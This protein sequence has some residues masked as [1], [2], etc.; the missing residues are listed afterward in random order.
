MR[1]IFV[2]D[3]A[4]ARRKLK[5]YID[6]F[7]SWEIVA[8]SID[9]EDAVKQINNLQPDLVLLDIQLTTGTGFEVLRQID[10]PWPK[11][12]FITAYDNYAVKAFDLHAQ[13]YILKPF[14]QKRFEE[15]VKK[16]ENHGNKAHGMEK[17]IHGLIN[18]LQ[19]T[20]HK[21]LLIQE[22]ERA[23]YCNIDD[24]IY[25]KSE[26]NYV[27]IYIEDCSYI[28]R[29]SLSSILNELSPKNFQQIHRSYVVNVN[30]IKEIQTWFKGGRIFVLENGEKIKVSSKFWKSFEHI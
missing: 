29:R 9:V 2:E 4:P 15:M 24:I 8:I 12:V 30:A 14:Q 6:D 18:H 1:V 10:S 25:I 28:L 26:G 19:S 16:V 3:E 20:Y 21:R 5:R 13:D 17:K 11:V 27:K 22:N 7:T 23:F